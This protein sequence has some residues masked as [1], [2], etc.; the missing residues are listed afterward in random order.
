[1]LVLALGSPNPVNTTE[2]LRFN[3]PNKIAG[4]LMR[5]FGGFAVLEISDFESP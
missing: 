5:N 1:M 4:I 2:K 3:D